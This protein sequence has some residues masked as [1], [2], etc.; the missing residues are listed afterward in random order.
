[1]GA[2]SCSSINA[3]TII[4]ATE[5]WWGPHTP[6]LPLTRVP[7]AFPLSLRHHWLV[8]ITEFTDSIRR[9]LQ[10][11]KENLNLCIKFWCSN[12]GISHI[13]LLGASCQPTALLVPFILLGPLSFSY[14]LLLLMLSVLSHDQNSGHQEAAKNSKHHTNFSSQDSHLLICP[15]EQLRSSLLNFLPCT[16]LPASSL[17]SSKSKQESAWLA[18]RQM[19]QRA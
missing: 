11:I 14:E 12:G 16:M 3:T 2:P 6:T 17:Q 4:V 8:L 1:M 18:G 13:P 7:T 19:I 15:A 5:E 10:F 9:D